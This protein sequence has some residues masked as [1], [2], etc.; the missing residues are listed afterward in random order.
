MLNKNIPL[1]DIET[2]LLFLRKNEYKDPKKNTDA[3]Q[4]HTQFCFSV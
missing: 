4:E 2:Q 3:P 1:K